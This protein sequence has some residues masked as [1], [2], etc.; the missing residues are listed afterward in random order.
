MD[1]KTGTGFWMKAIENEM[2]TIMPAFALRDNNL[3][4]IEY[5]KVDCCMIFNVKM[6]LTKKA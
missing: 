4:P 3:V 1:G 6:D 2:K 5:K